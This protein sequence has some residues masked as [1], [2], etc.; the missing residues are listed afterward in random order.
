MNLFHKA[1]VTELEKLINTT[2]E[3]TPV[4]TI[5]VDYDGEV[6]IDPELKLPDADLNKFKYRVQISTF[7]KAYF[8]RGSKWMH[9]LFKQ[10]LKGWQT[11]KRNTVS[12][13]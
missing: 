4:H 13:N 12:L 8:K 6:V 2:D 9:N 11:D 10:L 1:S 5:V 3:K 7:N